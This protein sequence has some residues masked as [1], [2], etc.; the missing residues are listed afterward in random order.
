MGLYFSVPKNVKNQDSVKSA[1]F[2]GELISTQNVLSIN[3][4]ISY[5]FI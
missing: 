5:S 4:E 2:K 3:I 1:L